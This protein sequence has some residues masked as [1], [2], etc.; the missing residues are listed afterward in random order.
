MANL[1]DKI[2]PA[3]VVR[4]GD[5]VSDLTNDANYVASGDNISVLTNNS[6]YLTGITGQSIKNLSDVYSSMTPTDGQ[7]L[8]YDTTNGWQAED[9][10]GASTTYGDVGTYGL[11][12]WSGATQNAPGTT[13]AGSSLSP[14]NTYA[15]GVAGYYTGSGSPSGTWRLMGETGYY[16]G[17]TTLN[18]A[19][20]YVSVFVRIS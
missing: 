12:Y 17:T 20:M 10:G 5:N 13:V 11:F 19:D 16:S 7:V 14:A 1:S 18:R 9:G 4:P 3:G 15:Y 6:G 8:T 2:A